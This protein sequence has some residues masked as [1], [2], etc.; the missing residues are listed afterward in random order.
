MPALIKVL[1][2]KDLATGCS[3]NGLTRSSSSIT[4]GADNTYTFYKGWGDCPAGCIYKHYWT[5]KVDADNVT[6][7]KET[8][9]G[10]SLF[11]YILKFLI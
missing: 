3:V 9:N 4:V 8:T 5:F 11:D 6:L 2:E 10:I 1:K 7:V